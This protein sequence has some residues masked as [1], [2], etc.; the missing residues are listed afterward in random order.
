VVGDVVFA[1]GGDKGGFTA[2]DARSGK[3]LW[4]LA[5]AWGTISPAIAAGNRIYAGDLGGFLR[6]FGP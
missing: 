3:T 5:T 4:H 6:A 1:P 2:L